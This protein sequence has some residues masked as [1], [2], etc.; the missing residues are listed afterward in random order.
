[1]CTI[2]CIAPAATHG[3]G[4]ELWGLFSGRPETGLDRVGWTVGLDHSVSI[5]VFSHINFK[6]IK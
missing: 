1:M 4:I 2:L 5:V 6:A 3:S